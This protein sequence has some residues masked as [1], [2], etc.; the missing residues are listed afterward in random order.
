MSPQKR[1]TSL[2]Q[3]HVVKDHPGRLLGHPQADVQGQQVLFARVTVAR[4]G[5]LLPD[6]QAL[7]ALG[8]RQGSSA[9][10]AEPVLE[11]IVGGVGSLHA[12]PGK[13]AQVMEGEAR[14]DHQNIFFH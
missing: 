7:L 9:Y 1:H 3:D 5:S 11:G 13:G 10:L 14:A 12:L 8:L 4:R 6:D 2:P